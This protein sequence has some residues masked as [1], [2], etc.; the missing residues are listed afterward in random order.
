MGQQ[1]Q[2]TT[3]SNNGLVHDY[4]SDYH[5]AGFCLIPCVDRKPTRMW[6]AIYES[7]M[8]SPQT[9]PEV[10]ALAIIDKPNGWLAFSDSYVIVDCDSPEATR[11]WEGMIT[12]GVVPDTPVKVVGNRGTHFYYRNSSG[13]RPCKLYGD[14]D[15]ISGKHGTMIAGSW[16]PKKQGIYEI[17]GALDFG[18]VPEL[19]SLPDEEQGDPVRATTTTHAISSLDAASSKDHRELVGHDDRN[20][21]LFRMAKAW[22]E[23]GEAH[24]ESKLFRLISQRDGQGWEGSGSNHAQPKGETHNRGL[25]KSVWNWY[26]SGGGARIR[27]GNRNRGV[28]SGRIRR[29][30]AKPARDEA[31]RLHKEGYSLRQ[32]SAKVGKSKSM[33]GNYVNE[34]KKAVRATTT[35]HAISSLDTSKKSAVEAT[36]TTHSEFDRLVA[37]LGIKPKKKAVYKGPGVTERDVMR[38]LGIADDINGQG[39]DLKILKLAIE[40][41]NGQIRRKQRRWSLRRDFEAVRDLEAWIITANDIGVDIYIETFD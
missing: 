17:A 15:I 21:Q 35:T 7:H 2:P 20:K 27:I 24:T 32:I 11:R 33:V 1:Q 6:N 18:S 3:P 23:S 38:L 26:Q 14:T 37:E 4:L 13:I 28:A 36:Q 31:I 19:V 41:L 34:L 39:G 10:T 40:R 30:K 25:A 5:E 29:D 8:R 9:L 16:D 12:D 22:V